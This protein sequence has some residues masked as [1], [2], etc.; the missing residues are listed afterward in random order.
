MGGLDCCNNSF[1][2][3]VLKIARSTDGPLRVLLR[4]R[5]WR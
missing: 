3:P 2:D 5:T 1:T 4:P